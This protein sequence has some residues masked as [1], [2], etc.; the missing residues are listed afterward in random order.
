MTVVKGT[1][2]YAKV[3]YGAKEYAN[4]AYGDTIYLAGDAP[5]AANQSLITIGVWPNVGGIFGMARP[6]M[7]VTFGSAAPNTVG[8]FPILALMWGFN[9]AVDRQMRVG[10]TRGDV[11]ADFPTSIEFTVGDTTYRGTPTG[12]V[13]QRAT[14][15]LDY[16]FTTDITAPLGDAAA[17]IGTTHIFTFNFS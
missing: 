10:T 16:D 1:K 15:Q 14:A 8:S 4:L 12:G 2:G 6:T 11:L 5:L 13:A 9:V 7:P 17:D 3:A